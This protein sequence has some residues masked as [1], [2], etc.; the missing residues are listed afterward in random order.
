MDELEVPYKA[1]H[2]DNSFGDVFQRNEVHMASFDAKC[3]NG[4]RPEKSYQTQ[5]TNSTTLTGGFTLHWVPIESEP[6][7]EIASNGTLRGFRQGQVRSSRQY[8]TS[9]LCKFRAAHV[10]TVLSYVK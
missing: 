7:F 10:G 3:L 5:M 2:L 6:A 8:E 4:F 9:M 1:T